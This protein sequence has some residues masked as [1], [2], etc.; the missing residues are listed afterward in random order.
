MLAKAVRIC[1]AQFGGLFL[2]E[3]HVL[4]LVAQQIRPARVAETLRQES[5]IDLRDHH[6]RRASLARRQ[7]QGAG[8]H[9]RSADG[10]GLSRS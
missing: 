6:P 4:R 8:A 1:E 7:N 5:V 9:C 3:G 10:R 2:C